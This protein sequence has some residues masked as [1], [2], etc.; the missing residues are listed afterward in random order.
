[1]SKE[2]SNINKILDNT[3]ETYK[4][5][6]MQLAV[7]K[8]NDEN[9]YG[10][11]VNKVKSF[12]KTS[13]CKISLSLSDDK[14]TEGFIVVRDETYP[15]LNLDK[16]IMNKPLEVRE[17][18]KVILC[19]FN[20][21][22][23]AFLATDILRIY[24]KNSGELERTA[25]NESKITYLTKIKLTDKSD[26]K[27]ELC[28]ILDVENCINEI[29]GKDIG[30]LVELENL[31]KVKFRKQLLIA[32]D[33]KIAQQIISE[34]AKK[35]GVSFILFNDGNELI[36]YIESHGSVEDIGLVISDIEMPIK[37]GFQVVQILKNNQKTKNIPIYLNTSMS[38]DGVKHKAE[39]LGAGFVEKTS[40]KKIVEIII[41]HCS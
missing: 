6:T 1:M 37:D 34:I 26:E 23:I 16:W 5:N 40:P 22:R 8:L 21:Q 14:Y 2:I 41:E 11:N 12:V 39:E 25:I 7:F 30:K 31:E 28:I 17:Y 9:Y 38:N 15:L 3:T 29:N 20:Q 19:E 35:T 36:K 10:I 18:A 13:D 27:E 24:N 4:N 32:E 33:S